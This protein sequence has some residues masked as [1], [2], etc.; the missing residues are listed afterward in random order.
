MKLVANPVA[1]KLDPPVQI[2]SKP[3]LVDKHTN[4]ALN[5]KDN[6]NESIKQ[7]EKRKADYETEHKSKQLALIKSSEI[8]FDRI[9]SGRK[10]LQKFS[11]EAAQQDAGEENGLG[12]QGTQ[13]PSIIRLRIDSAKNGQQRNRQCEA[14]R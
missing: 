6:L 13:Q 8:A 1:D 3:L 2:R 10:L 5:T 12:R 7:I 11:D 14:C 9:N 4:L